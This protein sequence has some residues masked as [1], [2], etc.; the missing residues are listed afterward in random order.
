MPGRGRKRKRGAD[1][2]GAGGQQHAASGPLEDQSVQDSLKGAGY[3]LT[4]TVC[5]GNG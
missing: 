4:P 5:W 3:E 2:G 1:G